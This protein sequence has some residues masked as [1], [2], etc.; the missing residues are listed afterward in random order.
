MQEAHH[1]PA[2]VILNAIKTESFKSRPD[3]SFAHCA[4]SVLSWI[5]A[6]PLTPGAS[7]H[8]SSSAMGS[9]EEGITAG[10]VKINA[11]THAL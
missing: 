8:P 7:S 11:H 2:A 1:G 3:T 10:A 4:N 6:L 9:P 5:L